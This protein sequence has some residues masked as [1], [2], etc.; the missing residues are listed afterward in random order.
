MTRPL[1]VACLVLAAC[2]GGYSAR[3]DCEE[4]FACCDELGEPVSGDFTLAECRETTGGVVEELTDAQRD[5]LDDIFSF[6]RDQGVSG[7]D[8][9]ACLEGTAP[10]ECPAIVLDGGGT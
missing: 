2:G 7:C 10:T 3:I 4:T 1:A 8:F 9:F 6:C 5:A